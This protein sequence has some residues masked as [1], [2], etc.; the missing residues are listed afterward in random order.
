M[1]DVKVFVLIN[2]REILAT[3][4][5]ET[6]THYNTTNAIA[7]NFGQDAK[8]QISIEPHPI[9]L[10]GEHNQHG[11]TVNFAKSALQYEPFEPNSELLAIYTQLK[12][13]IQLPP[14]TQ[15]KFTRHN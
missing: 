2:G 7:I 11:I 1:S 13:P 15:G 12:S 6:E 4:K 10:C 9:S 8:G 3:V 5:E 14:V